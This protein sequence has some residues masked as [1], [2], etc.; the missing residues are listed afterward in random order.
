[1]GAAQP[2]K[3]A[4]PSPHTPRLGMKHGQG[5]RTKLKIGHQALLALKKNTYIYR[6][7]PFP[8]PSKTLSTQDREEESRN[9]HYTRKNT[10]RTL[11]PEPAWSP[12]RGAQRDS[13]RQVLLRSEVV[14]PQGAAP[15]HPHGPWYT[16]P[17]PENP[18]SILHA[19]L[20]RGQDL[21]FQI[22]R[23]FCRLKARIRGKR[24]SE[25]SHP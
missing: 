22:W 1:M 14:Q 11:A 9:T 7:L 19:S 18:S 17:C 6:P 16:K 2:G 4:R 15:S 25:L 20:P 23:D 3:Q 12:Q 24:S 13:G 21:V 8:P 10:Q 5:H